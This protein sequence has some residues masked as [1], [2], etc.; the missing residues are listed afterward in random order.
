MKTF[1]RQSVTKGSVQEQAKGE[2]TI[3]HSST[4]FSVA[5]E[6]K[7]MAPCTVGKALTQGATD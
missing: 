6:A 7:G 5:T 3:G 4:D 1:T 2:D